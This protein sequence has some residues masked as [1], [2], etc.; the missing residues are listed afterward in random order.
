VLLGGWKKALWSRGG[1]LGRSSESGTRN[2]MAVV[3]IRWIC[4]NARERN[5]RANAML[6]ACVVV[7]VAMNGCFLNLNSNLDLSHSPA[8]GRAPAVTFQDAKA[9]NKLA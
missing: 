7:V 5:S 8:L 3:C 6:Q 9:A 4:D 1:V 2:M